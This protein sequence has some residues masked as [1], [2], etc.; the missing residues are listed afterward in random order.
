MEISVS[1]MPM[2]TS[3]FRPQ[4]KDISLLLVLFSL[5]PPEVYSFINADGVAALQS[6]MG[7]AVLSVRLFEPVSVL[8]CQ[9]L[10][11][12]SDGQ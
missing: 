4:T 7:H 8:F 12:A 11:Q 5:M 9:F 1:N 10:L 3:F 6:V 2:K